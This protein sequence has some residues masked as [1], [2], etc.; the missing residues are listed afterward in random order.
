LFIWSVRS[1]WFIW[2]IWFVLLLDPE[3]LNNQI[4]E[5]DQADETDRACPR[6][7][8]HRSS[9][10]AQQEST[11]AGCSKRPSSKAAGESKPEEVPTA[12]RG[13]VRPF[14]GSWRTEKHLQQFRPPRIS[15]GTLMISMSRERSPGKGASRRAGDRRVRRATFSA[16]CY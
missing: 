1:V 3:K 2:S 10:V 15:I 9:N 5:K 11:P 12:L 13:A 8:D 4:N 7:A 6:R 14:N 16:S